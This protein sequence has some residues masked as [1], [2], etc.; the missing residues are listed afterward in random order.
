MNQHFCLLVKDNLIILRQ[1]EYFFIFLQLIKYISYQEMEKK[2][3]IQ[4]KRMHS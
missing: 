1:F 4:S 2:W 3:M